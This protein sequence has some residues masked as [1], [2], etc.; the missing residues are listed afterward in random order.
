MMKGLLLFL[1]FA[2]LS[3]VGCGTSES[4][5]PEQ[6]DQ[7][8]AAVDILAMQCREETTVLGQASEKFR[9]LAEQASSNS[10][11]ERDAARE[12]AICYRL[13]AVHLLS[14]PTGHSKEEICKDAMPW[15]V[16]ALNTDKNV[17][18]LQELK[19]AEQYFRQIAD[20]KVLKFDPQEF[21]EHMLRVCMVEASGEEVGK[22]VSEYMF[23]VRKLTGNGDGESPSDDVDFLEG[24]GIGATTI[25][26]GLEATKLL[27]STNFPD[28][29]VGSTRPY[30]INTLEN[31]NTCVRYQFHA[32]GKT[33]LLEWE[34]SK[35]KGLV[36]PKTEMARKLTELAEDPNRH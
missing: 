22:R 19:A 30:Y 33:I 7:F 8:R 1:A 28:K 10:Q 18:D 34:V 9:D 17:K 32:D 3:V 2:C 27:L 31:G 6:L 29:D 13:Y 21:F 20:G 25:R 11:Y 26:T 12:S 16:R 14:R 5:P 15:M 4:V 23:A 24:Y 36:I 35:K